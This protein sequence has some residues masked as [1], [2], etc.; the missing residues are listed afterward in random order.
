MTQLAQYD[1]PMGFSLDG[2]SIYNIIEN[3]SNHAKVET[4]LCQGHIHDDYLYHYHFSK[5]YPYTFG[6]HKSKIDYSL[7]P[8]T[9]PIR[10]S[11]T[12][13]KVNEKTYSKSKAGWIVLDYFSNGK[14]T[15]LKYRGSSTNCYDFQYINN[16][17]IQSENYCL[18]NK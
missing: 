4:D 6:C 13:I 7:Q 8:R 15:V 17:N 10:Q 18:K 3:D 1:V 9:T 12:P 2:H 5:N 11:G 16:K 14:K